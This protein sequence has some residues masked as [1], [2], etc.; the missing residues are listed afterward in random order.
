MNT[1]KLTD[2]IRLSDEHG[3]LIEPVNI[4]VRFLRGG[5]KLLAR[6]VEIKF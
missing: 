2:C 5:P 4:K 1:K 3:S 6:K